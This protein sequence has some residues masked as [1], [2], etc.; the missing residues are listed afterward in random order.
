MA[1]SP[2]LTEQ[3]TELFGKQ[4]SE[5]FGEAGRTGLKQQRGVIQEEF[6]PQLRGPRAIRV[7][8]EMRL[9]NSTVGA[10]LLLFEMIIRRLRWT[11]R[12]FASDNADMARAEFLDQSMHDMSYSWADHVAEFLSFLQYGHAVAELVYKRRL[13]LQR[14]GSSKPTSRYNDGKISWRKIPI[15][16]QET[17]DRWIFDDHGAVQ[18][19]VQ[20]IGGVGAQATVTIPINKALLFRTTVRKG[21]P[22]GTSLLRR[23]YLSWWYLKRFQEIEGVGIERDLAGFPVM[24]I[25]AAVIKADGAEYAAWKDAVRNIRR[26]EQEGLVVPSDVDE[27]SKAPLYEFELT[28]AGGERQFDI[29][30][31]IRRY[32]GDIAIAMMAD[33]ILLGQERVGSFALARQKADM[34]TMGLEAWADHIAE[35]FNSHAVPRLFALNGEPLDRLPIIVHSEVRTEDL[36]D[37]A[38]LIREWGGHIGFTKPD[39][40]WLRE[41]MGMPEED[42]EIVVGPT[43]L[44]SQPGTPAPAMPTNGQQPDGVTDDR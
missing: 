2:D 29:N 22:E 17:I 39:L 20:R 43:S 27:E 25:P 23:A 14:E 41:R 16:A 8:E 21:S 12:P 13:G 35:V 34:M 9:N 6:L 33:L 26:D 38:R 28:H 42:G 7:Y 15:R 40:A 5:I 11:T 1:E 4:S 37:M 3:P 19:M 10:A 31:T 24:K 44:P 30:E 32:R 36:R 18:G